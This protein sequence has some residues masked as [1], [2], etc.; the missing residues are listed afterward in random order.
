ME[1]CSIEGCENQKWALGL[2]NKHYHI[3]HY[4][5]HKEEI[6][7]KNAE[8]KETH[9]KERAKYE[10]MYSQAHREKIAEYKIKMRYGLTL[11]LYQ[12]ILKNQGNRC[13]VCG[14][15]SP[16]SKKYIRFCVDHEHVPGYEEMLPEDKI[17]YFR[18][19]LCRCCNPML[20]EGLDNRQNFQKYI[21]YLRN[22]LARELDLKYTQS[23]VN[24]LRQNLISKFGNYC[25]IEQ[26]HPPGPAGV[27]SI[28]HNHTTREIR[29]LLCNDC[30]LILGY[31]KDSIEILE[32]AIKYIER[33]QARQQSSNLY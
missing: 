23:K 30:N 2:C 5:K 20:K 10:A 16:G 33:Y 13:A 11:K 28:D 1:T 12:E 6:N 17:R 29:G 3:E 21:S 26:T 7:K 19:L 9:R 24:A 8:Y 15:E 18:G 31:A 27:F 32:N 25:Q 14:S 4:K 22:P